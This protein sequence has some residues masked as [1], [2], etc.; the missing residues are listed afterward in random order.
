MNR[1]V[2]ALA[3]LVSVSSAQF[4]S[5]SDG[6]INFS[7]LLTATTCTIAVDGATSA[8]AAQVILP[9][10]SINS[11]QTAGQVNGQT[12]FNITLAN[13]RG[14]A[15]AA[16]AFFESGPGVDQASGQLRNTGGAANV[17]LQLV[18]VGTGN[19]ILAGSALQRTTTTKNS[20]TYGTVGAAG[21]ES[22]DGTA[23][24]P[25]AVRYIATGR[26]GAGTVLGTVTYAIDYQ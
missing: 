16:S 13:C 26:A 4:A 14:T 21:A 12:G 11:L 22:T 20:I 23:T 5:A 9:T 18:D 15:Q 7:G 8:A 17:R 2:L 3:V 6:T 10:V 1:N 24:L 25:Y 19:P